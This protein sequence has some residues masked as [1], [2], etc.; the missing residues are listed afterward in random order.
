MALSECVKEA[1]RLKRV[2]QE[3]GFGTL[4]DDTVRCDNKSALKLAE[5]TVFHARS[6]DID[7][8]HNFVRGALRDNVLKLDYVCTEEVADFLTKG[9]SRAKHV[10]CVRASGLSVLG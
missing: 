7:I 5:N 1:M 9:L 6:K 3:L 4:S 8:R 10:E 2:L